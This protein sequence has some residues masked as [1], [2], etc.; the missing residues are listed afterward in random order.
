MSLPHD[1]TVP[2]PS[3]EDEL[4]TV[5]QFAHAIGMS[6]STI[7]AWIVRRHVAV[8]HLGRSVRIPSS[9]INRLFAAGFVPP[10]R[11]R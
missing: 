8:V 1:E 11:R 9:E 7:R 3:R 5:P 10:L 2:T 4:L 6:V